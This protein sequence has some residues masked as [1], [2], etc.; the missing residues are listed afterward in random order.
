[1]VEQ[2]IQMLIQFLV[3]TIGPILLRGGLG[4]GAGADTTN[5]NKSID[6]DFDDFDDEEDNSVDDD[7]KGSS[8]NVNI[9]LPTFKPDNNGIG[10]STAA[11]D[12]TTTTNARIDLFNNFEDDDRSKSTT[13][14]SLS[15]TTEDDFA[16]RR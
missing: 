4:G 10:T 3:R 14:A 16:L 7:K 8:E 13:F 9:S 1:M 5:K 6:D 15:T 12:A 11:V 2:K